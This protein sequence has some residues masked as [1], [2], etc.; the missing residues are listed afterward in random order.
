MAIEIADFSFDEGETLR[1]L[2]DA[3]TGIS[4]ERE[5]VVGAV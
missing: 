4:G 5:V 2:V 1:D 3:V